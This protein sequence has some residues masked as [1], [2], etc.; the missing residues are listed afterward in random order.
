MGC[1]VHIWTRAL[2]ILTETIS[3]LVSFAVILLFPII[4]SFDVLQSEL[5]TPS[6]PVAARSKARFRG[7]SLAGIAGS[8]SAGGMDIGLL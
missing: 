7:R 6:H 3:A 2:T 4:N 5:W 1:S 8:N